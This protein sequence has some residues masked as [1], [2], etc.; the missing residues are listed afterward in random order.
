MNVQQIN[1]FI[2]PETG[3]VFH[4]SSSTFEAKMQLQEETHLAV[5]MMKNNY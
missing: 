4:N 5:H 3:P 1:Y 2:R